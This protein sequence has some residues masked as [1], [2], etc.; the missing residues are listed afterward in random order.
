MA[1][2]SQGRKLFT[3]VLRLAKTVAEGTCCRQIGW[4]RF[5]VKVF[6]GSNDTGGDLASGYSQSLGISA[7][8]KF[9]TKSQRLPY[10]T[11]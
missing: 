2:Q 6:A 7:C 10:L 11:R 8:L 5:T 4:D 9:R 3:T 1:R